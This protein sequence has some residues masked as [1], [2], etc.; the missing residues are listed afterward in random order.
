MQT[1]TR[2]LRSR[3][4]IDAV[5]QGVVAVTVCTS[6]WRCASS[7]RPR[8][9]SRVRNLLAL[10][11]EVAPSMR[12]R[13]LGLRSLARR[14]ADHG[15]SQRKSR[16]PGRTR[17]PLEGKFTAKGPW[18]LHRT[19]TLVVR[20][21]GDRAPPSTRRRGP[22]FAARITSSGVNG[23]MPAQRSRSSRARSAAPSDSAVNIRAARHCSTNSGPAFIA[24]RSLL[25]ERENRFRLTVAELDA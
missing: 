25:R 11:G 4:R 7:G 17:G 18:G 6:G 3:T 10:Q 5:C 16:I 12:A 19:G 8:N 15:P 23:P 13:E 20:I 24:A 21:A 14:H 1:R 9:R 2:P 22:T